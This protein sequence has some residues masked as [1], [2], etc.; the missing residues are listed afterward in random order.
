MKEK[1]YINKQDAFAA[2][3]VTFTPA[4]I[5]AILTPY[6]HK[7]YIENDSRSEDGSRIIIHN[8]RAAK[9]EIS[10]EMHIS[11][12]DATDLLRKRAALQTV[13]DG[14]IMNIILGRDEGVEYKFIYQSCTQ[15]SAMNSIAKFILRLV[16]PNP[17]DR[18]LL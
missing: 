14:R 7:S 2:Y 17:K 6:S 13:F 8:T 3:G 16:E 18:S 10:I 12:I 4:A 5:D 11:G 9:R 1:I 15:F